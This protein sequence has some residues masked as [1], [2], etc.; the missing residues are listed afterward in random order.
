MYI[1]NSDSSSF[2]AKLKYEVKFRKRFG[3]FGIDVEKIGP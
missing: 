1:K 3:A 2:Y